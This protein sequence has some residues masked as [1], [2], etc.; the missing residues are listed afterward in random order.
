[1]ALSRPSRT[2]CLFLC[3]AFGFF[4]FVFIGVGLYLFVICVFLC[5]ECFFLGL[6]CAKSESLTERG[7][8]REIKGRLGSSRD[9]VTC[10]SS[11]NI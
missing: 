7:C 5:Y 1:M 8:R 9:L 4:C 11:F 2:L 10:C 3:I 6:L